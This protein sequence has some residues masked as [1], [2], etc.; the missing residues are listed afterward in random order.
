MAKK[1]RHYHG[2]PEIY[3]AFEM[4][5]AAREPGEPA[6]KMNP[7]EEGE[8]LVRRFDKYPEYQ[9]TFWLV[10]GKGRGREAAKVDR[11]GNV[12]LNLQRFPI[13][14]G[15]PGVVPDPKNPRELDFSGFLHSMLARGFVR[16]CHLKDADGNPLGN[17]S[18]E[19]NEDRVKFRDY[20]WGVLDAARYQQLAEELANS[21]QG[22]A[23]LSDWKPKVRT[24]LANKLRN[25]A[26]KTADEAKQD[27]QI[28]SEA[29][30]YLDKASAKA[31][32]ALAVDKTKRG[33]PKK[34][35]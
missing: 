27:L 28:L 14:V 8:I 16:V 25:H 22:R 7:T 26:G 2:D 35:R 6:V 15:T 9:G 31:K 30:T 24:R 18:D 10:A 33:R 4:T 29:Q 1:V 32:A 21:E 13:H 3:G 17:P 5:R 34:S 12:V 11:L 23:L 19:V 20:S